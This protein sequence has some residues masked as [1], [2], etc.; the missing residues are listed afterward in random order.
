MMKRQ[1][2]QRIFMSVMA[3]L[4]ALLMVLP[5]LASICAR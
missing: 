1:K 4:L 2:K 3:G 5:I